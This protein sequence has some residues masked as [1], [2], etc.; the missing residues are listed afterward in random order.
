MTSA[1]AI[2]EKV[3]RIVPT[4]GSPVDG[5]ALGACRAI[6]RVLQGEGLSY[7]DLAAAI[8]VRTEIP[9]LSR[10]PPEWDTARWRSAST[11]PAPDYRPSR[12]KASVFTPTQSAI[13]R[14]M[15]LFCRNADRGRLSDRER[16]FVSEI[17][18]SRRELTVRQYDWLSTITDRLDMEDRRQ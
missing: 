4:L 16:A 10:T 8:P 12:R 14:R 9:V 15:A 1:P 2:P 7:H 11:R 6:G 18:A 17:S 5:E 3:R 13:H